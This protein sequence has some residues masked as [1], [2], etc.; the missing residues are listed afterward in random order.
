MPALNKVMIIGHVGRDA[1]CKYT[2]SGTAVAN[3]SVAVSE[4]Y[5]EKE[6]TE[7][8]NVTVWAKL[9]EVAGQYIRKGMQI[10]VEGSQRTETWE[11]DGVK[12]YKT[13]LNARSFQFLGKKGDSG[14]APSD[15]DQWAKEDARQKKEP[16]DAGYDD[17]G[18]L[19]PPLDV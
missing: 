11:K 10:Y 14:E 6:T 1:E 4:K 3:F 18:E 7:W 5:G 17:L 8:F 12:Q 16:I 2:Q 13:T 9:A 15:D 19:G